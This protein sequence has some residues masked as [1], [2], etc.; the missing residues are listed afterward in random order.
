MTTRTA[1]SIAASTTATTPSAVTPARSSAARAASTSRRPSPGNAGSAGMRPSTRSAS[2]TVGAVPA[3]PVARGSGHR[4]PRSRGRRPARRRRRGGR[5]NRRRRR[6]C[7][8]RARA[9]GSGTRRPCASRVGL[10]HAAVDQAHVGARPAHVERDRVGEAAR[11]RDRRGRAHP[12][13][14]TREQQTR[15]MLDRVDDGNEPA[16]R[17]HHQ[18]L[19]SERPPARPRYARHTGRS[20]ASTTVVT[21]RSYSRNSGDTS[22]EHTDVDARGRAAP[23]AT[24]RSW[25][26][27]EVGVEQAHR[28]RVDVVE[29]GHEPVERL[30]LDTGGVEPPRHLEAQLPGHERRRVGRRTGRRATGGPGARSRCTSAK[31]RVGDQR[32]AAQAPLEQRVGRHRRAVRRGPRARSSGMRST[33]ARDG[34]R[35]GRRHLDDRDRRRRRRR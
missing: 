2:V 7:G 1:R 24:A 35:R 13:R 19:V 31:P 21:I 29:R 10:R 15:R 18:H 27:I 9:A 8:S 20:A 23:S 12:G 32:D 30:D 6:W 22:C 4:R 34:I 11:G 14:R 17:R 33:T 26:R 5:S 16:G 28:D 3:A 25:A